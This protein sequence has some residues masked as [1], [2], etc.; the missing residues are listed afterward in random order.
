MKEDEMGRHVAFMRSMPIA[1]R[2][3]LENLKARGT[4]GNWAE[5]GR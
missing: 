5:M 1:F 3:F 4:L 2:F